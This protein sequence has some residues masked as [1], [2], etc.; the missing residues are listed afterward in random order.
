[1]IAPKKRHEVPV[2]ADDWIGL[3]TRLNR[4]LLSTLNESLAQSHVD[5]GLQ[6]FIDQYPDSPLAEVARRALTGTIDWCGVP[7][8]SEVAIANAENR[9]G[10]RLP[11]SYR[12]FLKVSNG[13]VLPGRFVDI[14]L[15][16]ELIRPF[17]Q[18][19]EEIVQ[20]RREL[21]VDPVEEAFQYHLDRAIQVTGTP[22]MGD[23]FFLLDTHRLSTPNECDAHVYSRVDIDWFASFAHLML[24]ESEFTL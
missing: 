1:M 11:K 20:I 8:A 7:G 9:L 14:L 23:D 24:E 6:P 5:M 15:P 22:Q 2:S 16:V 21:V 17:G 19:N 10:V 13:F 12:D 3:L 18:D 4:Q